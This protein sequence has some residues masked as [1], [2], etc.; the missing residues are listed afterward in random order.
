MQV[1]AAHRGSLQQQQPQRH[2]ARDKDSDRLREQQHSS[3]SRRGALAGFSRPAPHYRQLNVEHYKLK[4]LIVA[5]VIRLG[6]QPPEGRGR[7][8]HSQPQAVFSLHTNHTCTLQPHTHKL[9]EV[10]C[11][12]GESGGK[13]DVFKVEVQTLL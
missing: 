10:S 9:A 11:S 5:I 8:D 3:R 2:V 7:G 6:S 13:V 1:R 4:L 12:N